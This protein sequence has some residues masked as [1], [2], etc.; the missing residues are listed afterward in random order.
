MKSNSYLD[1]LT[2]IAWAYLFLFLNLSANSRTVSV[3][4]F[5][6]WIG[7]LLIF[8]ALPAIEK[9]ERTAALLR[10]VVVLLGIFDAVNWTAS[11]FTGKTL[12]LPL[13]QLIASVLTL[14]F[15]FQFLTD[16]ASVASAHGLPR[17]SA[18]LLHMRTAATL[19]SAVLSVLYYIGSLDALSGIL[20]FFLIGV[21]LILAVWFPVSLF[22]FRNEERRRAF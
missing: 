8:Q 21:S 16:L 17:F 4:L 1:S 11:L 15:H 14:Y 10:P 12:S 3:N 6:D 20:L 18:R 22:S 19:C 9:E 2:R 5:P 7:Y 13:L